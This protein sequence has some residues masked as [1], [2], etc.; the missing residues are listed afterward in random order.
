MVLVH[1]GPSHSSRKGAQSSL[2]SFSFSCSFFFSFF[3]MFGGGVN[4]PDVLAFRNVFNRCRGVC[5]TGPRVRLRGLGR[6]CWRVRFFT[7]SLC[8]VLG[9]S[10]ASAS[11]SSSSS[12][13]T[14]R[15]LLPLTLTPLTLT[16]ITLTPLTLTS[17]SHTPTSAPSGAGSTCSSRAE[18][19]RARVVR[20]CCYW[21]VHPRML[22]ALVIPVVAVPRDLWAGGSP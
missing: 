5:R 4:F 8:G 2:S 16:L 18:G 15:T 13:V 7:T 12:V 20:A 14:R 11:S 19:V 10:S 22:L 1:I 9:F 3:F 17:H 21:D 6:G